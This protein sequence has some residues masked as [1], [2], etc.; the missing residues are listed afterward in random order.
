MQTKPKSKKP[1]VTSIQLFE[2]NR[3][4][5]AGQK[6]FNPMK[7]YT[8]PTN[9][10]KTDRIEKAIAL[11]E[12]GK[13]Y[14]QGN[15]AFR[16]LTERVAGGY[17]VTLTSCDCADFEQRNAEGDST[18]C[19]HQWAAIGATAAMLIGDIRKAQSITALEATGKQYADAMA[20]LPQVFVNIA[21]SEY[22]TNKDALTKADE[23]LQILIKPQPK[24]NGTCNGI[25]I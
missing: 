9:T 24:S 13:V 4:V 8:K 20:T 14:S 5:R 10:N 15:G 23:D 18:P 21:R 3:P 19:K 16:V 2:F 17:T 6:E 1:D 11:I 25:E 12:S 7:R 22:R